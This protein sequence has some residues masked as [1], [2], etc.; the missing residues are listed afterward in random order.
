MNAELVSQGV[1]TV[2]ADP[3]YPGEEAPRS[4]LV[5]GVVRLAPEPRA[6]AV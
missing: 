4:E 1:D 6:R 5:G 2:R 3:A